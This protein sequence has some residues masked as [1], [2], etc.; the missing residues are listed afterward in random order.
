MDK[1]LSIVI[2]AYNVED[3]IEHALRSIMEQDLTHDCYEVIVVDDHSVDSTRTIIAECSKRWSN[4][5]L[6][7]NPQKSIATARNAAVET[8]CGKWLMY[9]DADDYLEPDSL[10]RLIAIAE[11]DQLDILSFNFWQEYV[12]NGKSQKMQFNWGHLF[13]KV[14]TG[15]EFIRANP[16]Y[17]VMVWTHMY[18]RDF[19]LANDLLQKLRGHEDEE[20]TPRAFAL[21]RRVEHVNLFCYTYVK[22]RPGSFMTDYKPQHYQNFVKSQSL[23]LEFTQTL[24]P[25]MQ[26]LFRQ[27]ITINM[28]GALKRSIREGTGMEHYMVDSIQSLGLS[29]LDNSRHSFKR[30]LFNI[31][32]SLFISFYRL[33][34]STK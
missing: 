16:L 32:P 10:A 9:V 14:V 19:L 15:E 20:V 13:D 7:D 29:P 30:F 33:T 22:E 8:A 31:R 24:S 26:A 28:I 17:P 21:A 25:S 2:P 27:R 5:R 11:R 34:H 3:Y 1:I 23:L 4:I 18:R 12:R 6:I